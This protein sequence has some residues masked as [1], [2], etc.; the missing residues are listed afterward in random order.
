[1]RSMLVLAHYTGW[2]RADLLGLDTDE[3]A[4]WISHLP[5]S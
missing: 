2:S 1:M 4:E 5:K 3:L